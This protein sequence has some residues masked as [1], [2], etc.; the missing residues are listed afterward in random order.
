MYISEF[1]TNAIIF[2]SLTPNNIFKWNCLLSWN[3]GDDND[4]V[5]DDDDNGGKEDVGIINKLSEE[6][7]GV[8]SISIL[9]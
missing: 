1:E 3:D 4:D 8:H 5:D 7:S 6:T 2:L 9:K